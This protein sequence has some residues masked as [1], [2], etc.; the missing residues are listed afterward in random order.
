MAITNTAATLPGI[1]VP[2][3]VGKLITKDVIRWKL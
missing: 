2:L 1:T 3:F